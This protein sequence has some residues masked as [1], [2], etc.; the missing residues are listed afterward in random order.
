MVSDSCVLFTVF[1]ITLKRPFEDWA[2]RS[3][4]LHEVLLFR[5]DHRTWRLYGHPTDR[6][7]E[8][9]LKSG[10]SNYLYNSSVESIKVIE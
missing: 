4:V 9:T 2:V 1:V 10:S 7:Y 3:K 5:F 6:R 8:R